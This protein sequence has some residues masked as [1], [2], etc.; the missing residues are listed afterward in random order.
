M[1]NFIPTKQHFREILLFC[2]NLKQSS[3]AS[4]RMLIEVYGKD[5]PSD[6]TCREWFR[7]FKIGDYEIRD[8]YRSGQPKKFSDNDIKLLLDENPRQTL[9]EL[10]KQL[11]VT[12][13]AISKRLKLMKIVQR[14]GCWIPDQPNSSN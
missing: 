8:K 12:H 5:V 11:N 4:H 7:R 3:A 13:G 1:S 14:N 2:F 10:A 9:H 6:A